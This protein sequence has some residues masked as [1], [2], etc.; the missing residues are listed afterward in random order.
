M[1]AVLV[2]TLMLTIGYAMGTMF[3]GP[4]TGIG[5]LRT[6]NEEHP[7]TSSASGVAWLSYDPSSR[8]LSYAVITNVTSPITGIHLHL[9]AEG[10]KLYFSTTGWGSTPPLDP[11]WGTALLAGA[12]YINVHTTDFTAGEVRGDVLVSASPSS[13]I[14]YYAA[15]A[16]DAYETVRVVSA[17]GPTSRAVGI[18]AYN[19]TTGNSHV[20][21]HTFR[22]DVTGVHVHNNPLGTEG[23]NVCNLGPE[24]EGD[25]PGLSPAILDAGEYYFNFHVGT[26]G[27]M[28]GQIYPLNAAVSGA[29][30]NFGGFL[31][32]PPPTPS[33]F[34]GLATAS[35]SPRASSARGTGLEITIFHDVTP[36]TGIALGTTVLC[37]GPTEC[38]SPLITTL[39]GP[40]NVTQRQALFSKPGLPVTITTTGLAIALQGNL[41]YAG[42]TLATTTFAY[43]AMLSSYDATGSSAPAAS[44]ASGSV[45]V[46]AQA[47]P[48]MYDFSFGYATNE[49]GSTVELV[50]GV[51][52]TTGREPG[53]YVTLASGLPGS[54]VFSSTLDMSPYIGNPSFDGG[55]SFAVRTSALATGAGAARGTTVKLNYVPGPRVTHV[56]ELDKSQEVTTSFSAAYGLGTAIFNPVDFTVDYRVVWK[57]NGSAV[58]AVHLHMGPRG[59]NGPKLFD[60]ALSPSLDGIE[61]TTPPLTAAQ[62][63]AF[64]SGGCYFNVHTVN[65]PSGAIRGQIEAPSFTSASWP[66][67]WQWRTGGSPSTTSTAASAISVVHVS[68]EE[69]MPGGG[70][71]G[72]WKAASTGANGDINTMSIHAPALPSQ[73]VAPALPNLC[74]PTCDGI[75]QGSNAPLARVG[76]VGARVGLTYVDVVANN[77]A[78]ANARGEL[79]ELAP[80]ASPVVPPTGVSW[81]V[82]LEGA[83]EVPPVSTLHTGLAALRWEAET[84]TLHYSMWY[85][86]EDADKV[87]LHQPSGGPALYVLADSLASAASPV[88]G[89]VVIAPEHVCM[90]TAGTMYINV[91]STTVP[92]GELRG[93]IMA[94]SYNFASFGGSG[95][96]EVPPVLSMRGGLA[97]VAYDG[98]GLTVS[99][100]IMHNLG[101][102]VS[103][104]HLHNGAAGTNGPLVIDVGVVSG[105]LASPVMLTNHP[106][107]S[108]EGAQLAAGTVYLNLHSYAIPSGEARGQVVPVTNPAS[109]CPSPPP[110]PSP[111]SPSLPSPPPPPPASSGGGSAATPGANGDGD[112]DEI[113]KQDNYILAGVGFGALL[114]GI[115]CTAV[116]CKT[117]CGGRKKQKS[118]YDLGGAS[119]LMTI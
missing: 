62:A 74:G 14:V 15:A 12:T 55:M 95:G 100:K 78:G 17:A 3:S 71:F 7:V 90:L 116:V 41:G 64:V 31:T 73:V 56:S 81:V 103:K 110:S 97:A 9:P 94:S 5:V 42:Q 52:G 6:Y 77:P 44:M 45:L 23:A 96:E 1:K 39:P 61:G 51:N 102:D 2:M 34:S 79:D 50:M 98:T 63:A 4:A 68:Y 111:P 26:P 66:L 112:E 58:D 59:E 8:V 114:L 36:V 91:H 65:Y 11:M 117:C 72:S 113:F 37:V 76:A 89:S 18:L 101:Y 28:R 54:G 87:H 99:A 35:F 75:V 84:R 21:A 40:F 109:T 108:G 29:G 49:T 53:T 32:P 70:S 105:S 86:V 115:V 82:D 118:S 119:A 27:Y 60:L 10:T 33:P 106:V 25:C 93:N 92:S 69:E 19:T 47:A 20:V 13:P 46:V 30:A 22:D 67:G 85:D 107:A 43:S 88:I 24:T 83:N 57:N 48:N 38:A 104:V 16:T 80:V